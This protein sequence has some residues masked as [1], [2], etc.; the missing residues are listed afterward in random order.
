[1][2]DSCAMVASNR[3]MRLAEMHPVRRAHVNSGTYTGS[4]TRPDRVENAAH[5]LNAVVRKVT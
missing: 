5:S 2:I 4:S 1:M 3:S